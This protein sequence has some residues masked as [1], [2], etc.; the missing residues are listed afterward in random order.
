MPL[1]TAKLVRLREGEFSSAMCEKCKYWDEGNCKVL[2]QAT[3]ATQTC[4]AIFGKEYYEIGS[5]GFKVD[6]NDHEAFVE[7]IAKMKAYAHKTLGMVDSPVGQLVLVED[8]MKPKPHRFSLPWD[9]FWEHV[10]Q[11]HLWT[12]EEADRLVRLGTPGDVSDG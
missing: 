3:E 11:A 8:G 12:Q 4:D 7:G 1:V 6:R 10:H 5:T 9:S 2:A